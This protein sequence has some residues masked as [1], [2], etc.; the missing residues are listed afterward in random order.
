M[1]RDY[2]AFLATKRFGYGARPGEI[3]AALPDPVASVLAQ[4][5]GYN[6]DAGPDDDLPG[7]VEATRHFFAFRDARGDFRKQSELKGPARDAREKELFGINPIY[8][9]YSA[10]VL[11]RARLAASSDRPFI[12]RLVAFWSNHFCVAIDSDAIVRLL[13]GNYEREAIRPHV[14]GRFEDML[15]ATRRHPAMLA[16][17]DNDKSVGPNSSFGKRTGKGLN[18]NLARETMELHTL[19]VDG[20]YDQGDVIELSR[21]LTGW[22]YEGPR[23]DE[24]GRFRFHPNTHEPGI[25]T[26]LG[27]SYPPQGEEQGIAALADLARH[28]ATGRFLAT[29]MVRHFLG[30]VPDGGLIDRLAATYAGSDG[31]LGALTRAL[32]A[33]PEMWE[34]AHAVFISPF[35]FLTA[36][37]RATGLELNETE[38]ARVLRIFGQVTW[39]PPSPAGWPDAPDAWLAP[40]AL[41]E[42][43]DWAQRVAHLVPVPDDVDAFAADIL[44]AAYDGDTRLAVTRAET[45]Q[46][47]LAMLMM[48]PGMQRR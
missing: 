17:L 13:A 29:K 23:G 19:G 35:E 9:V 37:T 33:A 40:D 30:R 6:P 39:Q 38:V 2:Q 36:S 48:S 21:I 41:M 3:A 20:G 28:P 15:L 16:Y 25:R 26:L 10:E 24:P 44:G 42:R 4:L 8:T 1:S 47:A 34:P 27:T 45:R 14:L 12:E 5:D 22:S 11:A 31:D 18:E 43:L 32:V 46:Q 7:Q